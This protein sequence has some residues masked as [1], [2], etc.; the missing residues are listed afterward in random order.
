MKVLVI[1]AVGTTALTIKMLHKHNFEIVGVL[2]H[3]PLNKN[4]VSGLNDLRTLSKELGIDYFPYQKINDEDIIH[5][6]KSKVPDIIFAVGFS[7]LLNNE[8][9]SL[10]PMG[11]IGFHPTNL[12]AGRGRAPIAWSILEN[13]KAAAN[14]FLIGSGADDG[15]VFVQES[16][17]ITKDDDAESIVPKLKEAIETALNRWL[18]ELKKGIFNPLKQDESK[19][20]YYG[21]R[22]PCDSLIDWNS[23]ASSIDR[24]IKASAKPHPGAF[25]FCKEKIVTVWK[26]RINN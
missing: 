3:D 18:P 20:T 11:C 17:D 7:Q 16:F 1:G 6:G 4:R 9:L 21:K 15:P 2:G 10:A 14:F 5:W 13:E 24:L 25:T 19:A 26:S 22:E 8:W 12:P 23:D